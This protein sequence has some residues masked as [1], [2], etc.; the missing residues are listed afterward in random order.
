M[1]GRRKVPSGIE[2]GTFAPEGIPCDVRFVKFTPVSTIT[3][4]KG[5]DVIRFMISNDGYYDPYSAFLRILVECTPTG[6]E[7]RWLDRSAHSFI[8]RL[9]IRSNGSELE[10]L[11]HY[12]VMAAMIND[13]IYSEIDMIKHHW[14]GYPTRQDALPKTRNDNTEDL[15]DYLSLI[16][17]SS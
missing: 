17:P 3:E 11:D 10:R 2:Y 4:A 8:S 1:E 14:E 9:V 15:S 7:I 13:G 6:D 5:G 16:Y 12:D